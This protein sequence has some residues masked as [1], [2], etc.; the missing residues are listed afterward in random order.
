VPILNYLQMTWLWERVRVH[1]GAYGAFATFDWRSGA[2]SFLSYRDPNVVQTLDN[3]DQAAQFLR[4]LELS[5]DDLTKATIGAIGIL[6][7]YQ[8]P[9]AKGYTSM[10][11]FLMGESDAV[12]QRRR[13]EILNLSPD[14]FRAF[15]VLLEQVGERGS[16][17][18]LGSPDAIAQ[19]SAVR[20]NGLSLVKVM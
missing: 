19:A 6:D 8:L 11:R 7:A 9:D 12:R 14:D 13:D 10:L 15:G 3:Y 5:P 4:Q 16:V 20:P 1:G 18:V 17:V 2:F